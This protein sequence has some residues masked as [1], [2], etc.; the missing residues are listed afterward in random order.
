MNARC[1]PAAREV[2]G[3]RHCQGRQ[4][5]ARVGARRWPVWG[6]AP[7]TSLQSP[8]GPKPSSLVPT[9]RLTTTDLVRHPAERR[10]HDEFN[11]KE[12]ERNRAAQW[13]VFQIG[14]RLA[15]GM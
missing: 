13:W 1:R 3:I 9:E 12:Q 11:E 10:H 4:T 8:D 7:L 15:I 2:R 6:F 5:A 14:W